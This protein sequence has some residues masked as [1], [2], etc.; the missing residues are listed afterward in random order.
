MSSE[1]P[2]INTLEQPDHV[3]SNDQLPQCCQDLRER[4]RILENK[5]RS[6]SDEVRTKRLAIV[7]GVDEERILAHVE[8]DIAVLHINVSSDLNPDQNAQG[9]CTSGLLLFAG[10]FVPERD[11]SEFN[12]GPYVGLQ[13]WG[14]GNTISE[15]G[16]APSHGKRWL[17]IIHV[18]GA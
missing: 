5:V 6:M 9:I 14:D 17:P 12:F 13:L 2:Q 16:I 3:G 15:V 11:G 7:D 8:H 4:V 1:E 18:G 10:E